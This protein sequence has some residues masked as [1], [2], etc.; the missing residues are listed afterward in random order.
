[1]QRFVVEENIRRFKHILEHD[2]DLEM[3][4][5]VGELLADAEADLAEMDR[6]SQAGLADS[7][8]RT[9]QHA[10]V[11]NGRVPANRTSR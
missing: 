3:R 9:G 4:R 10:R 8:F 6:A 5:I 7:L 11:M 2:T 1:M